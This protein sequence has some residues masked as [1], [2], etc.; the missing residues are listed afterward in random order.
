MG[1]VKYKRCEEEGC[2]KYASYNHES[3]SKPKYCVVHKE[4]YMIVKNS[5]KCSQENCG[6]KSFFNYPN[7]ADPI[8]CGI[9]ICYF[10][11]FL[12]LYL[13]ILIYIK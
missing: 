4:A 2:A 9:L 3:E 5:K 12:F 11:L 13:L 6:K 7:K 10:Y 1:E 8:Y